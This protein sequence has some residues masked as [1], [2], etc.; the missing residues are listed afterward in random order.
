MRYRHCCLP[1]TEVLRP[2]VT[3]IYR[4]RR[5]SIPYLRSSLPLPNIAET[6]SG[7]SQLLPHGLSRDDQCDL[8]HLVTCRQCAVHIV[9]AIADAKRHLAHWTK[10]AEDRFLALTEPFLGV[11]PV[12]GPAERLAITWSRD[13]NELALVHMT[14]P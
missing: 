12:A 3:A 5:N 1:Q 9:R 10:H 6:H 8:L 4:H 7:E 13:L 2:E 11:R 14:L